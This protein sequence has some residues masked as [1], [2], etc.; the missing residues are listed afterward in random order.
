MDVS[1]TNPPATIRVWTNVNSGA[2]FTENGQVGTGNPLEFDCSPGTYE[3]LIDLV[4]L[5]DPMQGFE[6]SDTA[7]S[8]PAPSATPLPATLPLFAGGLGFVGHLAK[9]RK[10]NDKQTLATVDNLGTKLHTTFSS[11]S[12]QLK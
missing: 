2:S 7:L 4:S 5:T 1:V 11:I 6:L 10:Q 9:R 3:V 12:T 8:L